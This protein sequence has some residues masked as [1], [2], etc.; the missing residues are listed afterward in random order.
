[1]ALFINT[2]VSSL[3]AQINL[4][5]SNNSLRINQERLSS[6]L[7]INSAKDD[8]A[9]LAIT[10]RM[11]AQIRGLNQAVRNSND[12]ISLA[13]TAEGALQETTNI[14]Q[15]MRELSVQAAN[16]TNTASDR[17]SIQAE[18]N[19]LKEE[20]TR[21]AD[22]TAF[23]GQNILDGTLNNAS[24][25]VGAESGQTISFSIDSAQATELGNNSLETDN[26]NGIEAATW[27]GYIATDGAEAG[28]TGSAAGSGSS[29]NGITGEE[30]TIKDAD[31]NVVG[32]SAITVG[33]AEDLGASGKLQESLNA[34]DGVTATG[35]NAVK[36]D[37]FT[38][39]DGDGTLKI[40]IAD[41][42]GGA[43]V[44]L[45]PTGGLSADSIAEAINSK[46]D[47]T[48]DG[49][50]AV[51]TGSDVTIHH[52]SSAD[53]TLEVGDGGGSNDAAFK[54]TGLDGD[55]STADVTANI[56]VTAAGKVNVSLDQGYT[57][58]SDSDNLLFSE[59]GDSITLN[60]VGKTDTSDGN[61]VGSQTLDIVGPEGSAS[62]DTIDA[63]TTAAGIATAVNAVT[64]QTGVTAKAETS[65]TLSNISNNGQVTFKLQGSNETA[66]EISAIVTTSDYSSLATAINDVSGQTGITASLG[67]SNDQIT[68]EA[69]DGSDIKITDFTHA[70][71]ADNATSA[72]GDGSGVDFDG[73]DQSMQVTGTDGEAVTLHDGEFYGGNHDS[74]VVGGKVTFTASGD[75]TVTSDADSTAAGGSILSTEAGNANTSVANYVN[76][77]D[78]TTGDGAADAIEVLDAAIS[79]VDEIRSGLGAIQNRFESTIA[80]LENVA[81]NLTDARSRIMDAD[82]AKEASEMTQNNVK[83]QAGAAIL[84][85]ANQNPQLALQLLGG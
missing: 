34:L 68:L 82:I 21:I 56:E 71:S 69:A 61:A 22:T 31:G 45:T 23:N 27:Q 37:S 53:I 43:S 84:A 63:N 40:T 48:D 81:L 44:S 10:D 80:N 18:V 75:F 39:S 11:T 33:A 49:V 67:G 73:T 32:G 16:D 2:N 55:N 51:S 54:V 64:D 26:T 58:E 74:T 60:K 6:G 52:N 13:Q 79:K 7:R 42:N 15:R 9:G 12:G 4:S 3:N 19:Q 38:D 28:S 47:L 35:H 77:I 25:Q 29:D 20:L 1:M 50:F 59:N 5:Q 46:S 83:Q 78:L 41:V 57:I 70:S 24:F 36:L 66:V 62:T 30:I 72:T 17:A 8:A 14:L 65:A 85:Q 76:D